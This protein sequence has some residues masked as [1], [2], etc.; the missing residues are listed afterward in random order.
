MSV[1]QQFYEKNKIPKVV[2]G[3]A[4]DM[5]LRRPWGTSWPQPLVAVWDQRGNLDVQVTIEQ[6]V[7]LI[8]LGEP[9]A[10]SAA[11]GA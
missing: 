5:I 8:K 6:A 7:E 11:A 10:S 4:P 3:V 1:L 9:A 2:R